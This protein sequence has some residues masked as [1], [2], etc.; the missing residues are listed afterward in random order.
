[1]GNYWIHPEAKKAIIDF[2]LKSEINMLLGN[3]EP[4]V[5][6]NTIFWAYVKIKDKQYTAKVGSKDNET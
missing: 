3:T 6:P 2:K 4:H 5:E 1:M